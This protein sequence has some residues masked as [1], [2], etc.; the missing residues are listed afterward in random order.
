[1]DLCPPSYAN[2]WLMV[3]IFLHLMAKDWHFYLEMKRHTGK[4]RLSYTQRFVSLSLFLSLH[5]QYH[6]LGEKKELGKKK[7][8]THNMETAIWGN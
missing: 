5:A 4:A 7:C 1:M 2:Y 6:G 3:L 8:W